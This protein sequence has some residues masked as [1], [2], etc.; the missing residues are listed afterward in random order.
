[1]GRLTDMTNSN[2]K[3][4]ALNAQYKD[5]I[6]ELH[7]DREKA[8]N[9]NQS[10]E[11]NVEK[12]KRDNDSVTA[13]CDKWR[14]EANIYQDKNQNLSLVLEKEII[15]RIAAENKVQGLE[16]QI[17]INEQLCQ[18]ILATRT[19]RSSKEKSG[20]TSNKLISISEEYASLYEDQIKVFEE[21][22]VKIEQRF[23][24]KIYKLKRDLSG[25]KEQLTKKNAQFSV[26]EKQISEVEKLKTSNSELL[27]ELK[28]ARQKIE[29]LETAKEQNSETE[30][31]KELN[32]FESLLQCEE[33]RLGLTHGRKDRKRK[34]SGS[35]QS[36]RAKNCKVM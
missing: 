24:A 11:L 15:A 8:L 20:E 16:E 35:E 6:G 29:E 34:S 7:E 19:V 13:E 36:E 18:D 33:A 27:E 22:S 23:E 21:E 32:T 10:F 14:D 9:K 4:T 17:T 1:M 5:Q 12:L 3:L 30:I 31:K 26:M 28:E 25:A 2:E